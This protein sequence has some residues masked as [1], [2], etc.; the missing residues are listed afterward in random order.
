MLRTPL[1]WIESKL[2][3]QLNLLLFNLFIGVETDHD[4][5]VIITF[6]L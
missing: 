6:F 1:S 2:K 4:Y 5:H 3:L